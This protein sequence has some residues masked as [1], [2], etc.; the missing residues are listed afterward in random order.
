LARFTKYVG[1][2]G[3]RLPAALS[4]LVATAAIASAQ[5]AAGSR[6][7]PV[8]AT[9]RHQ[10]SVFGAARSYSL[11]DTA[12]TERL[13]GLFYDARYGRFRVRADGTTL[14]YTAPPGSISGTTP[15]TGRLDFA[16]GDRDTV[17]VYGRTASSPMFLDSVQTDAIGAAATATIDLESFWLGTPRMVGGRFAFGR[18]VGSAV[19]SLRGAVELEPRPAGTEPIYWRGISWLGGAT[20]AADA[21]ETMLELRADVRASI[22]DSLAGR[23]LFPGG[24]LVMLRGSLRRGF[25]NP[26]DPLAEDGDLTVSAFYSRTIAADRNNQPNRLVQSGS[27][28][29][30]FSTLALPWREMTFLPS[31]EL[32]REAS[33]AEGESE[34]DASNGSAWATRLGIAAI[35]PVGSRFDL[36]PEVG[37]ATGSINAD[38]V[39]EVEGRGGAPTLQPISLSS[40]TRGWWARLELTVT[41]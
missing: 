6:T 23:N 36:M 35:A 39:R 5:A 24:G 25:L 17:T 20:I 34:L 11:G 33:H 1:A 18:D 29:G 3:T 12:I 41:Y 40:V 26:I 31:L 13:G 21:G 19:L 14:S 28:V 32:L 10:V 16:Y 37:W 4:F 8:A 30:A 27:F 15:I 7:L 38:Y 22:A 2:A 9:T